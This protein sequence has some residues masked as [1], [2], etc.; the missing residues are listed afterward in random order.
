MRG[1]YFAIFNIVFLLICLPNFA[2][3][4]D[5]PARPV[6]FITAVKG[7]EIFDS[8][9]YPARISSK[10]NAS[11]L[12]DTDG[13]VEQIMA[14]LGKQVRRQ[15]SLLVIKNT[16]PIYDYAPNTVLSPVD[17][18][19]S[20][21]EVTPGSRVVRGQRL[22]TIIDPTQINIVIEVAASD[23]NAIHQGSAGELRLTGQERA[24]TVKVLGISPFVDPATGTATCELRVISAKG[25][26]LPPGLV[27][28]V[29]FKVRQ[30]RGLQIPENAIVYRN[31]EPFVRIVDEGKAKYQAVSI[32]KAR[33]G[34][35]EITKGLRNGSS[36]IIRSSQFVAE[37]EAV[38]I[39]SVDSLTIQ[40]GVGK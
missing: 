10:I 9:S 27:G 13:A 2:S 1:Y 22:A 18:V 28:Q 3:A 33:Q 23:L 20:S 35:I 39:Q 29:T 8:L 4:N 5:E 12:A 36:V 31:K 7:H 24:F 38:I 32:G 15:E 37:G 11:V 30:H 17:G 6:V 34:M 14:P 19:V 26:S 40:A 25:S 21:V 16:D